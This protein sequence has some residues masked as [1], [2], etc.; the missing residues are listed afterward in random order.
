MQNTECH[1]C[2][3]KQHWLPQYSHTDKCN[4]CIKIGHGSKVCR[5]GATVASNISSIVPA[6]HGNSNKG[7][8][9]SIFYTSTP[10]AFKTFLNIGVHDVRMKLDTGALYYALCETDWKKLCSPKLEPSSVSLR[11]TNGNYLQV[12][13]RLQ[14]TVTV[15]EHTAIT[16]ELL[17][18][19]EA[20]SLF[21]RDCL[22]LL[23]L[24]LLFKK[25]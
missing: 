14:N 5:M 3:S 16:S 19:Y 8:I 15:N 10:V 7:N 20:P 1:H 25:H 11:L 17:A 4:E 21:G 12:R 18:K 6:N 23:P 13:G 24:G 2:E 22:R 9:G